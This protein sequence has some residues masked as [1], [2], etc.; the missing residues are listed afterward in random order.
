M[1]RKK[2]DKWP[3]IMSQDKSYQD[4]SHCWPQHH[5]SIL[6]DTFFI[7]TTRDSTLNTEN[8][9]NLVTKQKHLFSFYLNIFIHFPFSVFTW[10]SC[11]NLKHGKPMNYWSWKKI[12]KSFSTFYFVFRYTCIYQNISVS[13]VI[14]DLLKSFSI[15]KGWSLRLKYYIFKN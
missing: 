4:H 6:L 15:W 8:T 10:S 11:E 13:G 12:F 5:N 1:A 3:D 9:R 2:E 14:Y 7:D